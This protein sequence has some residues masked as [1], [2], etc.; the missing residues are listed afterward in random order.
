MSGAR[1]R[2]TFG[3][4]RW[5]GVCLAL[6]LC[7]QLRDLPVWISLTVLAAAG[8]RLLLASRGRD[9]PPAP[10]RFVVAVFSIGLLF[11]QFRTFNGLT[12]GTALLCLIAGLKLLETR[13][14][15]DVYVVAMIIYFLCLAALLESESFWLLSYLLLVCWLTTATLLRLRGIAGAEPN[16]AE[17]RRS[18]TQAGKLLGQA[19]PVALAFW[20]FFP[21]FGGPLWQMPDN[22]GA[23]QSG[24]S[25]S[26][27]PG[28]ITDLANSD[29]VAFRV[30]LD[31]QRLLR[32]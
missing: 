27:T 19:L 26:M 23:A 12:A 11:L 7:T 29:E 20:L 14:Q 31:V 15:R 1:E 4:L 8:L 17:W 6:T 21:R 10:I 25:G 30:R 32:A 16:R 2:V 3:N 5:I 22:G 13:T 28:D 18:L 24:L 9:A